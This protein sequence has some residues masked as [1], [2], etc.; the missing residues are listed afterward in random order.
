MFDRNMESHSFFQDKW[1]G[2]FFKFSELDYKWTGKEEIN[3]FGGFS[4]WYRDIE[5]KV[6]RF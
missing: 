5:I 6:N 4:D 2:I 1:I 3:A